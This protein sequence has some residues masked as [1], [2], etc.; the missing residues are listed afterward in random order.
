MYKPYSLAACLALVSGALP[1]G[2]AGVERTGT[3]DVIKAGES[4]LVINDAQYR[5]SG[6]L[7]VENGSETSTNWRRMLRV[8]QHVRFNV[9]DEGHRKLGTINTIS[10]MRTP[11]NASSE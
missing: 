2:V 4:I 5:L 10:V 8:G 11:P 7:T 9:E 6:G 3:I 1:L